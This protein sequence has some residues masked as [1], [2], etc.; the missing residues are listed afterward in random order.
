MTATIETFLNTRTAQGKNRSV[1]L[2]MLRNACATWAR[3]NDAPF[4]EMGALED[5]LKRRGVRIFMVSWAPVAQGIGL[6]EP[7]PAAEAMRRIASAPRD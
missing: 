7:N 3:K 4:P 5:A 2:D 6:K 1:P